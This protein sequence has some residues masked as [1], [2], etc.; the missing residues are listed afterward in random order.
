MTQWSPDT[1]DCVISYSDDGQLTFIGTARACAKHAPVAGTPAHLDAVLAH[2][3]QKNAVA[4]WIS[5]QFGGPN[6][7]DFT[8]LGVG[9]AANAPASNDPVRVVGHGLSGAQLT[10]AQAAAD[11]KFGIGKVLFV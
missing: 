8:A 2:N 6:T 5:E 1:C 4:H 10:A 3:R 7:P 9:Y 11:A